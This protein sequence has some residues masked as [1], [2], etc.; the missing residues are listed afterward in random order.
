MSEKV[1][2]LKGRSITEGYAEGIALVTN[3][4]FGFTHGLDPATGRIADERHEWINQNVK[5]KVLVFP[6]GKSS[7][8]GGLFILEAVR[9]GNAPSGVINIET[10]PVIGAGFIMAKIFYGKE[11][12]VMDHFNK[13]PIENIKNGDKIIL[14]THENEIKIFTN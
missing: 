3:Q 5:G 4:F 2:I 7:S 11:I 14:N 6:Y 13:N 12:P 9:S 8:S 10:E 1:I